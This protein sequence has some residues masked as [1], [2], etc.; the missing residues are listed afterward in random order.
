VASAE[1][2]LSTAPGKK[3]QL[4]VAIAVERF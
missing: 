2:R 4:V 3:D 1:F